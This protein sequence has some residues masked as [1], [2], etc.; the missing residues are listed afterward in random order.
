M[1]VVQETGYPI[2]DSYPLTSVLLLPWYVVTLLFGIVFSVLS[3]CH[4]RVIAGGNTF[5]RGTNRA[6]GILE[7]RRNIEGILV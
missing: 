1:L 3:P 6:G 4:L 7:H 2:Q 5:E